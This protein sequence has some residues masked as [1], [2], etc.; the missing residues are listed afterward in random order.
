MRTAARGSRLRPGRRKDIRSPRTRAASPGASS[1]P[2]MWSYAGSTST[3]RSRMSAEVRATCRARSA[4]GQFPD[5]AGQRPRHR[6]RHHHRAERPES[7]LVELDAPEREARHEQRHREADAGAG[8]RGQQHRFADRRARSVQRRSRRDP[9]AREHTDRLADDVRDQDP[10]R[11]RRGD[12]MAQEASR[13]CG[14]R[15]WRVRTAARSRSWSMG[16]ARTEPVRWARSSTAGSA[17]PTA[18]AQESVA[19]ETRA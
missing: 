5:Q 16:A 7:G 18:R 12:R 10:P 1:G 9:R 4:V 15:R 11:D 14:S 19:R 17:G 6:G 13:S 2:R 3:T 8:A